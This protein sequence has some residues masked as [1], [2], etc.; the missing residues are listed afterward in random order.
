MRRAVR[1]LFF[2]WLTA[3]AFW[4]AWRVIMPGA[5][6]WLSWR[7]WAGWMLVW[8]GCDMYA[9]RSKPNN[10]PHRSGVAGEKP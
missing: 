10:T 4:L 8:Y 1:W 3:S 2:V 6:D 5:F 7:P 9:K